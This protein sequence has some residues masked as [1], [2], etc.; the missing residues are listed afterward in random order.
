ML[1]ETSISEWRACALMGLARDSWR[2][3]PQRAKADKAM[4]QGIVK[5]AHERRHP[6]CYWRIGELIRAEGT[7]VNDKRVYRL[8]RLAD[9][10]VRKHRGRKRLKLERTP[11][12]RCEAIN[13]AWSMDFVSNSLAH[14]RQI[15]CLTIIDDFSHECVDIAVDCHHHL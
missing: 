5:L 9:L 2:H 6:G 3:R 10:A 13:Q 1:Q 4:S 12:H 15:K 8:Y 7:A 11:L 14:G